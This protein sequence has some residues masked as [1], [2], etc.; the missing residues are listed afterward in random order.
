[1]SCRWRSGREL[2]KDKILANAKVEGQASV[3]APILRDMGEPAAVGTEQI[4]D[5]RLAEQSYFAGIVAP[6]ATK[7][8]C[9][10][11]LTVTVDPGD[12]E[13]LTSPD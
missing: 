8:G 1:M 11:G 3:A 2:T 12:T 4:A 9:K 7:D 13:D 10:L 5:Q 6:Q